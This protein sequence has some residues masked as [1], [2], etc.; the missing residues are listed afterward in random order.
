MNVS[1]IIR[2]GCFKADAIKKAGTLAPFITEEELLSWANEGNRKLELKLR[3]ARAN[4]FTRTMLSTTA[5]AEKIMGVDYTPSTSMRLL[6][7]TN[8]LTLPPDYQELNYIKVIT[9]GYEATPL[10]RMPLQHADFRLMLSDT[11][12]RTPGVGMF[13]DIQGERTLTFAPRLSS[14]LDVEINY[15][16]R[17]KR[18]F[19]YTA[20]TIAV[21]HGSSDVVGVGTRWQTGGPFD[22]AYLDIMFNEGGTAPVPSPGLVYD[23]VNLARVASITDDLNLTLASAKV[24]GLIAGSHYELSSLPVYAEDYHYT[25]ADYIAWCILAKGG[26]PTAQ[27]ALIQFPEN[28][29][30]MVTTAARRQVQDHETIEDWNPWG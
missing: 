2:L 22:S 27:R 19:K 11:T 23:G 17:S 18:L 16:A 13:F 7:G 20:G 30:D 5:V 3:Q 6:T 14:A 26:E 28:I 25:L 15:V 21:A 29:A 24:L 1:Q 8:T 9:S 10:T 4:Y 12:G